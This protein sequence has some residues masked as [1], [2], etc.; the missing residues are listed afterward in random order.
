MLQLDVE[1]LRMAPG[2]FIRLEL[3]EDLPSFE[4][5]GGILHF[6]APV[7]LSLLVSNNGSTIIVD[8]KVS[9]T[10]NL[11]CDRCLEPFDCFFEAPVNESYTQIPDKGGVEAVSYTGD[12]ID[13]TPEVIK[14]I[15]LSLPMKFTCSEDCQ[16]L[17]SICGCNLN[18]G[19]CE[20]E[21]EDI[22]PRL[23]ALQALLK[24]TNS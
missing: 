15:I 7:K 20:C 6:P 13:I 9:G 10:I 14:S 17:C 11:T 23:S 8:G 19:R 3:Q 4:L 21:N 16:G 12:V 24:K 5:H 2:D 1:R 22:D 18:K